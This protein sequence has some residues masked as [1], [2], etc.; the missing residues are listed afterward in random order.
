MEKNKKLLTI[1]MPVYNEAKYIGEAI[2]SLLAQTYKDFILIISDNGSTD[3]TP[4]I[5]KYYAEKDKRIIFVQHH[6]NKG[7][8][9]NF[10]YVLDKANTPF[11]MWA[12]GHYKWHPQFIEKLLPIIEKNKE[13]V[14][15][16][17]KTRRIEEDETLTIIYSDDYTTI[18]MANPA[19]RYLFILK[20]YSKPTAIYGIWRTSII[21]D[22]W[23]PK[24][25]ISL[26]ILQLLEASLK[27][28]FKQQKDILFFQRIIRK[29]KNIYK[30]QFSR[31]TGDYCS[32]IPSEFSLK[33]S[34][35]LENIK[36]L[37]KQNSS[38]SMVSKSLLSIQTI[39]FWIKRWYI[40]KSFLI[41]ILKI[42]LPSKIYLFLKDRVKSKSK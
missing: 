41:K 39:Y 38:L 31:I 7:S 13:L 28:K 6:K 29:E 1:G 23:P 18:G 21:K 2:E 34:L 30:E 12:C 26:D 36:M 8:F 25:V 42:I 37:Y 24:P 15:V 10:K 27:G 17:P 32:K 4:E 11:F 9:F 33:C 14:L 40:N 3:R 20:H 35:I 16:Y 22:C 19:D 5:C